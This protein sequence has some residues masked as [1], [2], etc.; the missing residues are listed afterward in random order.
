MS[1]IEAALASLESLKPG[2]KPKLLERL[3]N[4]IVVEIHC[5]GDIGMFGDHATPNTRRPARKDP[6]EIYRWHIYAA[7]GVGWG[8]VGWQSWFR[9]CLARYALIHFRDSHG[10][11]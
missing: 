11:H 2:E 1:P 4:S 10:R 3:G 9:L 6:S 5:R 8:G 7:Q